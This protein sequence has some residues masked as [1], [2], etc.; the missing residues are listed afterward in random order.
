MLGNL[1]NGDAGGLDSLDPFANQTGKF[2]KCSSLLT[3]VPT[4]DSRV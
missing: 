4:H 1:G 3:N 2:C